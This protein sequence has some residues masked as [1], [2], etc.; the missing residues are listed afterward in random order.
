MFDLVEKILGSLSNDEPQSILAVALLV[1][2]RVAPLTIFAP[3][4]ALR[5]TPALIRSSLVLALTVSLTPLALLT[6]D[7][8][9]LPKSLV[10]LVLLALREVLIGTVFAVV[11]SLPLFGMDW[12]GRLTDTWRGASMA[13]ILAPPTGEQSSPL[14]NLYLMLGIA[15]FVSIGGHRLALSAFAEGLAVAPVGVPLLASSMTN[16]SFETARLT[17]AALAFGVA[18]AAPAAASIVT[19]DV[20]LG[21]IARSA[22]QI[23]VF[24]AG[25][26]LR[27]ATGIFAVLIALSLTVG[28]LPQ[29]FSDAVA[30]AAQLIRYFVP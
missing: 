9:L 23:P 22:P 3:W 7:L 24:F 28:Q 21:L 5:K 4:L 26:P 12:A 27:A 30:S 16:I 11:T 14:G 17:G 10:L 19:V 8:S 29:I 6:V 1:A 18:L 2:A 25:M 15:I 20:S 13:Q